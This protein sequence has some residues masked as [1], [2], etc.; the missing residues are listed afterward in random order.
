M[1]LREASQFQIVS[2]KFICKRDID[3]TS[4]VQC[5]SC[6]GCIYFS[7]PYYSPLLTLRFFW[8][9]MCRQGLSLVHL[10]KVFCSKKCCSQCSSKCLRQNFCQSNA[11]K[12]NDAASKSKASLHFFGALCRNENKGAADYYTFAYCCLCCAF[13]VPKCML[14]PHMLVGSAW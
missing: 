4:S 8:G 10:R 11:P 9:E 7:A 5:A 1:F 12:L 14:Y 2:F 3:Y 6:A 13:V